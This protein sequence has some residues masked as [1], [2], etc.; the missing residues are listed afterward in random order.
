MNWREV[1][2]PFVEWKERSMMFAII[3]VGALLKK[4]SLH[5]YERNEDGLLRNVSK[6]AFFFSSQQSFPKWTCHFSVPFSASE[7]LKW[8]LSEIKFEYFTPTVYVLLLLVQA[9][10]CDCIFVAWKGSLRRTKTKKSAIPETT[11][12][13]SFKQFIIL[14]IY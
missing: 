7:W 3:T 14:L 8:R 13:I 4:K 6:R 10:C 1:L 12:F 5:H 9:Y 2:R 11:S